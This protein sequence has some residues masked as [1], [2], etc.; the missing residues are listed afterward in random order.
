MLTPNGPPRASLSG[1]GYDHSYSHNASPLGSN[2][3]Y[4]AS[5][6]DA[7]VEDIDNRPQTAP[8]SSASS[9]NTDQAPLALPKHIK[10]FSSRHRKAAASIDSS[11]PRQTIMKALVSRP[12]ANSLARHLFYNQLSS[13]RCKEREWCFYARSATIRSLVGPPSRLP[14]R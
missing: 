13:Q 9:S 4:P 2:P 5:V 7:A 6:S 14:C 8:D 11:I 1:D 12:P 10:S 3:V